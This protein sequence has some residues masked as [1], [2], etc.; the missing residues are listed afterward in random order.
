[1]KKPLTRDAE[2][3]SLETFRCA[4]CN[5]DFDATVVTWVD[6][7]KTPQAKQEILKWQFNNIRCAWCGCSHFSGTPF[8]YE[9]F[10]EG[11]LIA[12][13]P[14]IPDDRGE[15]ER[16]IRQKYGYYPRLEFFYDMAQIWMLIYFQDH[17][18]TNRN[19]R[20]LS[21]L[22]HGEERVFKMLS[23]LKES[24][25]MIE[26]REKLTEMFFGNV[27]SDE[28]ADLLGQAVFSLEEMLPW[29]LDRRCMCGEDLAGGLVC[30]GAP[31]N[32]AEH[33][34][35][36]SR[37]YAVYCSICKEAIAGA[38][39]RK[40]DRVYTWR[41]GTVGSYRKKTGRGTVQ[42]AARPAGDLR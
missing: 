33:E 24:P 32:L 42:K 34:H 26:I 41:L 17:Y 15:V 1:M 18:R 21:K 40:C 14:R 29:P 13:F 38:S 35:L 12:V 11:L 39:C 3:S 37:H 25:L 27:T 36:L 6:V 19:L 20:A 2:A 31:V 8:F 16:A 23:F 10:A 7:S 22:G 28:M 4:N 9:D 30:C 5:R